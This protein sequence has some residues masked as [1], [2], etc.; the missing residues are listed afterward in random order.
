MARRYGL[1]VGFVYRHALKGFFATIPEA[2]LDAVR[3]EGRVAYVEHDN[4]VHL[5]DQTL[6]WGVDRI[7]ADLSSAVAGDG[8]GSVDGVNAY[9]LDNGIYRHTD[10]R[11]VNLVNFTGDANNKD[12]SGH[13]THVAGTI[14]AK[15][16]DQDVVGV[17]PG[18][19][20]TGVKVFYCNAPD[21]IS[22]IIKGVDWVTANAARPAV[23]NMSMALPF[24]SA[25]DE[26]VRKS[27]ASGIFYSIAAGNEAQP[28]CNYSPGGAGLA[29]IDT[30]GDGVVDHNDSNGIVTTA[31]T[32]TSARGAIREAASSNYCECVDIWAPGVGILSTQLGGVITNKSSTSMAAPHVAGGAA[33]YLSSHPGASPSAVERALKASARTQRAL[34]K[35]PSDSRYVT[36]EYVGGF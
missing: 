5:T 26:A 31:S 9:V 32:A 33:L 35:D 27:A 22:V 13:G 21:N 6:P 12:C 24:Y 23:A 29:K 19:P 18:A 1:G 10:L 3:S 16:N 11:V 4:T 30:N 17:A 36:L 34:S 7:D 14:A 25:L 8:T 15:D 2:R 20:L 28:A